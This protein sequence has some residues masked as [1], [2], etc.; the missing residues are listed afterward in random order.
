MTD[1]AMRPSSLVTRSPLS[2]GA[3]ASKKIKQIDV[4]ASHGGNVIG[5]A[6]FRA[7]AAFSDPCPVTEHPT[8]PHA[9]VHFSPWVYCAAARVRLFWYGANG[10]ARREQR[11]RAQRARE[12]ATRDEQI[13][14]GLLLDNQANGPN[15]PRDFDSVG[16]KDWRWILS[17]SAPLKRT[18]PKTKKIRASEFRVMPACGTATQRVRS[19]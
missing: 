3:A 12:G 11:I 1:T 6:R 14:V 8:F 19:K 5:R 18:S 17:P 15:V 2:D 10:E 16:V 4:G 9:T 13:I 7:I